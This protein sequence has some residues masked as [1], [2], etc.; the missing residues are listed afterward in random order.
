MAA[1]SPTTLTNLNTE[2]N[3]KQDK[4]KKMSSTNIP[5]RNTVNTSQEKIADNKKGNL[6]L[7]TKNMKNR[8]VN[9]N[10]T[11][12]QN[13]PFPTPT[14]KPSLYCNQKE[15]LQYTNLNELSK[16]NSSINQM[17]TYDVES[18]LQGA[19]SLLR[20]SQS[21]EALNTDLLDFDPHFK[22]QEFD[23]NDEL[24]HGGIAIYA[25]QNINCQ[26]I[27]FDT[28]LDSLELG[29]ISFQTNTGEMIVVACYRSPTGNNTISLN[30][31]GFVTGIIEKFDKFLVVGDF[32]AH[33]PFWGSRHS[34]AS[35]SAIYENLDW[36]KF[37]LFN[38]H[39]YTHYYFHE[40]QIKY[41]YID[42]SFCSMN[43]AMATNWKV[44]DDPW[45]SDHF[46]IDIE[47]N[48]APSRLF[49]KTYRHNLHGFDWEKFQTS[50]NE[51]PLHFNSI[52]FLNQNHINRY[53]YLVSFINN[54]I[55]SSL[56][57]SKTLNPD[58][59]NKQTYNNRSMRHNTNRHAEKN[60]KLKK[61]V[62]WNEECDRLIRVRNATFKSLKYRCDLE[63]L[64]Q[65]KKIV[66][67]TKKKLIDIKRNSFRNFCQ[68]FSKFTPITRVW[69]KIKMF[70]NGLNRPNFQNGN[71]QFLTDAEKA[72]Q[73]L[74]A[75]IET[76]FEALDLQRYKFNINEGNE[77]LTD[78][79]NYEELI[80][81]FSSPRGHVRL[82]PA[83]CLYVT[84]HTHTP[85]HPHT[86]TYTI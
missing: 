72:F 27:D 75:P 3:T 51:A 71:R 15:K 84:T 1:A 57:K 80:L 47:I 64:I 50:L 85:T 78:P 58:L 12:P 61:N 66:A 68:T 9:M 19:Q 7:E 56:K 38:S 32:N 34:C 14:R 16:F 39:D 70:K 21:N 77:F 40:E 59:N 35:G 45:G 82:L 17:D 83:S 6:P 4:Q 52:E 74:G 24:E 46:P 49:K 79:I 81:V 60:S 43:L 10:F 11:L 53:D 73:E 26:R 25:K 36:N 18:T 8:N 41:S 5:I 37:F 30:D 76:S 48:V 2:S 63:K 44:M 23:R 42:L 54:D 86:H 65:Y 31:I 67:E 33:H 22:E 29:A 13:T 28:D 62:W 55:E 20:L 69:S